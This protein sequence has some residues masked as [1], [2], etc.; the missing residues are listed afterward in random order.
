MT[1]SLIENTEQ[2]GLARRG[3]L[4]FLPYVV[5]A[6][7]CSDVPRWSSFPPF[8]LCS[9]AISQVIAAVVTV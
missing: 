2:E 9:A 1:L 6:S 4:G 3:G 7:G 5:P 8:S